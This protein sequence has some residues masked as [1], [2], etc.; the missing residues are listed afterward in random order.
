MEKTYTAWLR[1]VDGGVGYVGGGF[2]SVGEAE[3]EAKRRVE[4]ANRDP[5]ILEEH[6]GISAI[7]VEEC[8]VIKTIELSE[9]KKG[10]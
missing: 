9:I 6:Q 3:E 4:D 2:A 7:I 10:V 5:F 1:F 8:V